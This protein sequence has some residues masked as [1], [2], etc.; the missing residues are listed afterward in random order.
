MCSLYNIEFSTYRHFI[1]ICVC[2]QGYETVLG[3]SGASLSGGQ[4][5]RVAIARA[6]LRNPRLLLLDEA[7]SALDAA[8]EKVYSPAHSLT[9]IL[10]HPRT[11]T[12]TYPHTRSPAHSLT[13]ALAHSHTYS[14]AHSLT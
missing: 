5:Q 12:L 7:T 1:L 3:Q 2:V 8:S 13:R 6:L 10:T 14:P 9:R 4:K 11:R